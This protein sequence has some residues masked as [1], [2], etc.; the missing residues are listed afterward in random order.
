MVKRYTVV[1]KKWEK[2]FFHH[3]PFGSSSDGYEVK[4]HSLHCKK[5]LVLSSKSYRQQTV[6]RKLP[7][8]DLMPS[9]G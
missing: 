6:D 4:V 8:A 9:L 5:S 7:G 3:M 2:F 1:H